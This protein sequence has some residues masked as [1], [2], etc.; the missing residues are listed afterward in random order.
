ML[1]LPCTLLPVHSGKGS[2]VSRSQISLCGPCIFKT[3][4]ND[5]W[6]QDFPMASGG[7]SGFRV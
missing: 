2:R 4:M 6:G 7:C 5:K 3:A 1:M